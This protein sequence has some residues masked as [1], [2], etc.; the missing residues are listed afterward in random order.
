M[1]WILTEDRWDSLNGDGHENVVPAHR[2]G[3][4]L[5]LNDEEYERREEDQAGG[6]R[7]CNM[8]YP[9]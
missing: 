5:Q 9:W 2:S 4:N 3:P 8:I 1:N 7:G 6:K